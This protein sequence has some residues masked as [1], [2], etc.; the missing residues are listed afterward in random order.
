[1]RRIRKYETALY[2]VSDLLIGGV[3]YGIDADKL[4]ELVL[5]DEGIVTSYFL[6]KWVLRNLDRFSDI[7]RIRN[8]AIKRIGY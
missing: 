5:R 4:F 3:Y 1:M 6:A 7:D 2:I 8:K